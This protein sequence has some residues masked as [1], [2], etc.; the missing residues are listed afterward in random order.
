LRRMRAHR[1]LRCFSEPA[2]DQAFSPE[3]ASGDCEL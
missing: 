3:R 1:L 2:R